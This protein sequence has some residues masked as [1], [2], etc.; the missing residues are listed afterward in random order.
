ML[1][2][3]WPNTQAGLEAGRNL[4]A[5]AGRFERDVRA[6]LPTYLVVRHNAPFLHPSQDELTDLLP[7]LRAAG[8]GLFVQLRPDP[9]LRAVA[10]PV[11][12]AEVRLAVWDRARQT[13]RATGVDPWLS[14]VLPEEGYVAGIRLRYAYANAEGSP[15]R[16]RMDW[17]RAGLQRDRPDP[18][19]SNWNLPTRG[20]RTTTVWIG[21]L[22][23]SFRIQP[24]NRP[25]EFRLESIELLVPRRGVEV[26]AGPNPR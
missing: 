21:D 5:Q 1:V 14:F 6:G 4:S 26:S 15:A 13:A 7:R 19:Y 25:C 16:F 17:R 11:D 8:V 2:L 23:K 22:V 9:P 18:G 20:P 10:I 3:L 24:D 12:P